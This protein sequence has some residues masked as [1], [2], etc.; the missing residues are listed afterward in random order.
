MKPLTLAPNLKLPAEAVTETFAIIA[1]RGM[2]KT[3][4]ASV[5]TEE[6]IGNGHQVCVIDPIG[7][8]WG[9][10][11][12]ADGKSAG[13]PVVILGGEHGDAPLEPTAGSVI[14]DFIVDNYVPVILD[15]SLFRK[16]ERTRFMSDFAE[17]L[18]FRNRDP[19]HLMVDEADAFAPQR[20]M[21]GEER[22][23][24]A[25]EDIVRRGRARGLGITLISQRSAV[26]NKDVLTQVEVL[27][28]LRVVSP[29]D[30][31]AVDEWVKVHM[32]DP[33]E[34]D[35][36]LASLPSLPIGEAWFWSPGWLEIFKRV[37]V[38]Q[39]KTFD[40][41]ATPKVGER[42][43]Q[44][45][46][47]AEIDIETLAGQIADT[48]EKAKADDP[49][50]LRRQIAELKRQLSSHVCPAAEHVE[51]RVM[52]DQDLHAI[53]SFQQRFD[54][55]VS[56]LQ[57]SDFHDSSHDHS[58]T[59]RQQSGRPHPRAAEASPGRDRVGSQPSR[60][61]GGRRTTHPA[62]PEVRPQTPTTG[63][64]DLSLKAGARR[65][66]ETLATHYPM[67]FT[68]PQIGTLTKFKIT[69]GTFS[70]YWSQIRNAGLL[71]ESDGLFWASEAGLDFAGV[72]PEAPRTT[73]EHLAMWNAR[74]KRG[75]REI[76][77]VLVN[78]YPDS[79]TKE[80]L[81]FELGMAHT[82]G[83]FNTYISHLRNNKLIE[84]DGDKLRASD[85][86]FLE[87]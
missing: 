44:P 12:S 32:N 68:K 50:E 39:R 5:M 29:Q 49:K 57:E 35:A 86:L 83:T 27:I 62:T 80:D 36:F 24:G 3:Y 73:A 82:G 59:N 37:K 4:L 45:K 55:I 51:V 16:G 33:H 1:K 9:L 28:S 58:H 85:W 23:L 76:L 21:K 40:S 10:R 18:Y 46:V 64:T 69:G 87:N 47:L 60:S 7:V 26:I 77:E 72:R 48:I 71:E 17:R 65:I 19:L 2:G 38:R 15:L 25:M 31:N 78:H 20:P 63:E 42:K 6:M 43:L 13:L 81:G 67:K 34:R 84:T 75:A 79:W 54:D 70:T 8:W 22:M 14:A 66:V 30:R 11:S 74:L 41:S 53:K 56:Q 52:T 61:S